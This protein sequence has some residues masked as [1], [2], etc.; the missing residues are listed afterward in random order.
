MRK[1]LAVLVCC[2]MLYAIGAYASGASMTGYI[3]DEKCGAKGAHAGADA[4]AKKCIES[5]EKA[6]FVSDESKDVLKIANQDAIKGHEGHHVKVSGT[7]EN[8]TLTIQN[9]EMAAE[10]G[11]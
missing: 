5:G 1:V 7:V 6:I 9:L 4:C 3:V 11:Q 8:G 10:K 2:T